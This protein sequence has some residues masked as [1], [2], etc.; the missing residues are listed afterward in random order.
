MRIS[1][2]GLTALVLIAPLT[3]ALADDGPM[4][5]APNVF[6]YQAPPAWAKINLPGTGTT[7]P[8]AVEVS[9]AGG[10]GQARAMITVNTDSAPVP[11]TKWCSDSLNRNK[12]Q[13]AQF[14]AQ[15]GELESFQTTAGAVGLRAPVDLTAHGRAIH[16]VMYFFAGR[17]D[18]KIAVTCACA[19]TDAA[20]FAPL[21]EAAMKTFKPF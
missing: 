9:N 7:Y 16:Y 15:I 1:V 3:F 8:A 4:I 13:F 14:G 6:S 21:F 19:A 17:G 11:L 2:L 10:A 12:I 20:H 18:T 5:V